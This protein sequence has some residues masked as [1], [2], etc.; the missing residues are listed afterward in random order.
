MSARLRR[1][2]RRRQR[3]RRCGGQGK[4]ERGAEGA[5]DNEKH[6]EEQAARRTMSSRQRSRRWNHHRVEQLGLVAKGVGWVA[7]DKPPARAGWV[8]MLRLEWLRNAV[9]PP[10]SAGTHCTLATSSNQRAYVCTTSC[11]RSVDGQNIVRTK[12]WGEYSPCGSARS[13]WNRYWKERQQHKHSARTSAPGPS[14][15]CA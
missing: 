4:V 14:R 9:Q 15:T 13:Y 8:S 1:T 5:E 10:G 6:S 12:F 2:R 3:S 11:S 7:V